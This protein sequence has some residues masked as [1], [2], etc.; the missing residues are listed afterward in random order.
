M[1][2]IAEPEESL[3]TRLVRQMP[4]DHLVL[5]HLT[6]SFSV[7]ALLA[8]SYGNRTVKTVTLHF[9]SLGVPW[10]S[11]EKVA[12]ALGN[13]E[14]LQEIQ[15]VLNDRP[16]VVPDW[17]TLCC[18]LIFL[19]HKINVALFGCDERDQLSAST[20]QVLLQS[21]SLRSLSF[22]SCRITREMVQ[23]LTLAL[24][25]NGST[26]TCLRLIRCIFP[27]EGGGPDTIAI[28]LRTNTSL[29]RF[30]FN[31]VTGAIQNA[32]AFEME[33]S[34]LVN[35]TLTGLRLSSL[36]AAPDG[37]SSRIITVALGDNTTLKYCAFVIHDYRGL[38]F[39]EAM[40]TLLENNSTLEKLSL[41]VHNEI[42]HC[43]LVRLR[44]T[45]PFLRINKSLKLSRMLCEDADARGVGVLCFETVSTVAVN[46]SLELL[47]IFIKSSEGISSI[48]YLVA[49]AELGPNTTLKTLLLHPNLD[50]FG[51]DQ[52]KGLVA[53]I[54]MNYGLERLDV[55]LPDPT[56][57]VGCILRLNK[58]GRRYIS[59][60]PSSISG[61]ID[62]FA[63]VSDNLDCVFIHL[64]EISKSL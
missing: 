18:V 30:V 9:H 61:S 46:S 25:G 43:G 13:L 7:D 62:V 55:G 14:A 47:D 16:V 22:K 8:M 44:E 20:M 27:D 17:N 10:S 38:A 26:F 21:R 4:S 34:L 39:F 40:R 37:M 12:K 33:Q 31:A 56:G 11:W 6:N 52:V 5:Q 36:L 63:G 23:C 60:G 35:T 29:T 3:A 48:E 1:A 19:R 24:N 15:L 57:E 59:R 41:S 50:S 45:V 49:L 64:L 58:A 53:L 32:F 51:G 28:A 54:R 2:A 42:E